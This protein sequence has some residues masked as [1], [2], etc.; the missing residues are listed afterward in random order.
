MRLFP[1]T[2]HKHPRFACNFGSSE[3][4]R[5]G[6]SGEGTIARAL[7]SRLSRQ[8]ACLI[9]GLRTGPGLR[10]QASGRKT[11]LARSL[12]SRGG[13]GEE[14]QAD[15]DTG[16]RQRLGGA[17]A[18]ARRLGPWGSPSTRKRD[19]SKRPGGR[20]LFRKRDPRALQFAARIPPVPQILLWDAETAPK[21]KKKIIKNKNKKTEPQHQSRATLQVDAPA[22]QQRL[23]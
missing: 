10:F 18:S 4:R 14:S 8:T 6:R 21:R 2:L 11:V 3:K 7:P 19:F 16:A 9:H 15:W 23:Q 20:S 5:Q 12:R 1:I 17:L 13:G 22:R